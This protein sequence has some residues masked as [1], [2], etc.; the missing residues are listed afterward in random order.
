MAAMEPLLRQHVATLAATSRPAGSAAHRQA[1]GYIRRHLEQAGFIVNDHPV[2]E[3]GVT[4]V[5]LLT[6]PIPDRADLPLLIVAA[7]YDSISDSPGAD[8]NAS[9]VAAL[10][11]LAARLGP[12]GHVWRKNARCRLVL[13]AYDL[14]ESG[15]IGSFTHCRDLHRASTP[16]LGMISLEMLGYTDNRPGSQRLP[17]HLAGLYPEVGNFIGVCGNETS[18]PLLQAVVEAMKSID[19]LPVEYIAVPGAGEMLYETRLS[20]H[21]SFW[22]RGYQALMITDTSFF[23]NPHYHE[24]SDTPDTLDYPFLAKVT[25]GVCEAVRRLV[26][27]TIR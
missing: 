21:S 22:D 10:L 23:R 25:D 17:P 7:H 5:N 1:A 4:G 15:L 20:D 13:A 11:E 12:S 24:A 3:G 2:G 6:T 16:V 18:L 27:G 26:S 14:E 8:D 19:G 9:A